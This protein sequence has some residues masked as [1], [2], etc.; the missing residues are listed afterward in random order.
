MEPDD[1]G[2]I[3]FSAKGGNRHTD[4]AASSPPTEQ[5]S[6]EPTSN[7]GQGAGTDK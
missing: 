3:P 7:A 2:E 4:K 1:G 6:A 5:N